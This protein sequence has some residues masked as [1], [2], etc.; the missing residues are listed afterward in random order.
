MDLTIESENFRTKIT[1]NG[2]TI[3]ISPLWTLSIIG[4]IIAVCF[5]I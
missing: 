1:I 5:L 4:G 2:K 3:E